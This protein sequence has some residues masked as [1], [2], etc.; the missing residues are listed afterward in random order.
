MIFA[1]LYSQAGVVRLVGWNKAIRIRE[2]ERNDYN[3]GVEGI[4][5]ISAIA[6][7]ICKRIRHGFQERAEKC[8][9]K[10]NF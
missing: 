10:S 4:K 8:N 9:S 6:G 2:S 5:I 1:E 7:N 3:S